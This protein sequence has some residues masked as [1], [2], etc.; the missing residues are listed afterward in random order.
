MIMSNH[1]SLT[2][3][4]LVCEHAILRV[5]RMIMSNRAQPL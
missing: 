5:F 4:V 3:T 2:C 1:A